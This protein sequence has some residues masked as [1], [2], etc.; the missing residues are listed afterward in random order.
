MKSIDEIR[1][2]IAEINKVIDSR[3]ADYKRGVITEM[4]LNADKIR[5]TSAK[6]TLLWVI[7]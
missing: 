7:S 4:T 6:N 5:L 1:I 2:E 3:I